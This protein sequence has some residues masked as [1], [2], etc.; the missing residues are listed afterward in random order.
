MEIFNLSR[1][2]PV[3]K[4]FDFDGFCDTT[5]KRYASEVLDNATSLSAF[6]NSTPDMLSKA[7]S[8]SGFPVRFNNLSLTHPPFRL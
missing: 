5:P 2:L 8:I 3:S 4:C 6:A 1:K 7:T